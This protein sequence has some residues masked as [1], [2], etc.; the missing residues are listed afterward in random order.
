MIT[1]PRGEARARERVPFK[2]SGRSEPLDD[3]D[4]E[5]KQRLEEAQRRARE[6]GRCD[7]ADYLFLRAENDAARNVG[8]EWLLDSFTSLAG[9]ANRAGAT[10]QLAREDSHRFP[11]G[12][13]TMVGARLTLRAGVR[14]LT[15][16]AGWPRTPGDG[17]V[18]GGGLANGRI[19][20]FGNR[21]AG[22]DLLLARSAGGSPQWFVIEPAGTRTPLAEERMR[23]HLAHLLNT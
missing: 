4:V 22:E 10:L 6:S 3:L 19:A 15:V 21:S 5:W 14:T 1:S 23:R 17:I 13:S 2:P 20:H 7:V 18:R 11:F 16:E 9:E 12:N 8:L